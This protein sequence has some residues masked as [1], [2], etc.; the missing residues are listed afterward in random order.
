MN[1]SN[2]DPKPADNMEQLK[3][4]ASACCG[5]ECGCHATGTKSKMR[6]VITGP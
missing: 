1:S 2:E 5:S 4:Q 3:Q 6:G